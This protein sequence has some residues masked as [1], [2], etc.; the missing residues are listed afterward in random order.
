MKG[1]KFERDI[2][3]MERYFDRNT[4]CAFRGTN[5]PQFIRFGSA[6]DKDVK[7]GITSGKLRLAG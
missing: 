3:D 6:R 7:L 4:K 5:D 2:E 1:S